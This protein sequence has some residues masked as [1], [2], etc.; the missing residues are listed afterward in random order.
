MEC[1]DDED[2]QGYIQGMVGHND[3][4]LIHDMCGQ[5]LWFQNLPSVTCPSSFLANESLQSHISFNLSSQF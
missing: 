5:G 2:G 4:D 1:V 3:I